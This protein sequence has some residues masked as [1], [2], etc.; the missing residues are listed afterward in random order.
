MYKS[1]VYKTLVLITQ[2]GISMLVPIFFVLFVT[3]AIRDKTGFDV[4]VYGLVFGIIVGFRNSYM[5]IKKFIYDSSNTDS[6]MLDKF[7][8]NGK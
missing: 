5:L 6:E 3:I 7:E 1:I 4:I 2:V 8:R